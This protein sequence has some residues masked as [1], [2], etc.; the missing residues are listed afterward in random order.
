M[1]PPAAPTYLLP[2]MSRPG[3]TSHLQ[4][5]RAVTGVEASSG[6]PISHS[7]PR[8][9]PYPIRRERSPLPFSSPT[10][11]PVPPP[12]ALLAIDVP[13]ERS[14]GETIR[15]DLSEDAQVQTDLAER[16]VRQ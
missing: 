2:C 10:R 15:I 9:K 16:P 8:S 14:E 12:P 6:E 1:F 4:G 3:I 13:A 11:P 5:Y 7:R